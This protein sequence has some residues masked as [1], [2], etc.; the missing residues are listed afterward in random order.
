MVKKFETLVKKLYANPVVERTIH[1]AWQAG[2]G[3]IIAAYSGTHGDI[4]ALLMVGVAASAAAVKSS[5]VNK[6]VS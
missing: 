4:R 3:A 5:L 2:L 1:T 6:P